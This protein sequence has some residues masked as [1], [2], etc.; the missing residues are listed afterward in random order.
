MVTHFATAEAVRAPFCAHSPSTADN[1]IGNH[2]SDF[3]L[4]YFTSGQ[5]FHQFQL[6]LQIFHLNFYV[7]FFR[8][9][10]NYMRVGSL[11]LKASG[12]KTTYIFLMLVLQVI[13]FLQ[14]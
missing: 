7:R 5:I 10:V 1:Q 4:L 14:T 12:L 13:V 2:S 9:S 8:S 11:L 6:N 3:E